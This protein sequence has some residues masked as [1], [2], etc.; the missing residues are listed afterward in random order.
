MP[1]VSDI[2]EMAELLKV[3]AIGI[4]EDKCVVIFHV[5]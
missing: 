5:F 2:M 3:K 1:S 4:E